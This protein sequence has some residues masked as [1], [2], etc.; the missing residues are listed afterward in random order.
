[1]AGNIEHL[2]HKNSNVVDNKKPKLPTENDL[3]YG[4]IAINYGK[5]AETISIKNSQN[6]IVAFQ[7][8]I[9]VTKTEFKG[10]EATTA[11]IVID[12]SI[13]G[14]EVEIYTKEEVDGMISTL[15]EADKTIE[16]KIKGGVSVGTEQE[17]V[18]G[19]I[20]VDTSIDESTE[21]YTKTEVNNLFNSIPK[22][23]TLTKEQYEQL[24]PKDPNTYY[25]TVEE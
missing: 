25:F 23:V 9:L 8:E 12:E 6:E 15:E 7:N 22:M 16:S 3:V 14:K 10:D 19:H 2:I 13:D 17:N 1:M 20:L 5:G 18:E 21:V 24:T 4:E 11:K